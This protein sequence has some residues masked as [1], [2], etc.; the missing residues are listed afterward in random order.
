M[1]LEHIRGNGTH[2]RLGEARTSKTSKTSNRSV[3]RF[4]TSGLLSATRHKTGANSST[5]SHFILRHTSNLEVVQSVAAYRRLPLG[6]ALVREDPQRLYSFRLGTHPSPQSA[7][8]GTNRPPV[9]SLVF[10]V[11]GWV[12][13]HGSFAMGYGYGYGYAKHMWR[14][15]GRARGRYVILRYTSGA[16]V[17]TKNRGGGRVERI[18]D[19]ME[20]SSVSVSVYVSVYEVCI[21]HF[22]GVGVGVALRCKALLTGWVGGTQTKK[23]YVVRTDGVIHQKH[24]SLNSTQNTEWRVYLLLSRRRRRSLSLPSPSSLPAFLCC[25]S[26]SCLQRPRKEGNRLGGGRHTRYHVFMGPSSS[27]QT[28]A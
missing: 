19:Q 5:S 20:G 27:S 22:S 12:T 6:P 26:L 17:G 28:S 7:Q 25:I 23:L 15:R 14:K 1:V 24:Q 13:V 10:H 8:V 4:D 16:R 18:A 2:R 9:L 11:L 21:Y 3:T